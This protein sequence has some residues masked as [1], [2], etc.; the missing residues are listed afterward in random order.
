MTIKLSQKETDQI[1]Q[2][3]R[4]CKQ[5]KHADK[6]K[7]ILML[8][9]GFSCVEVGNILLLDDDTIRTYGNT[10]LSYGAGSLLSDKKN[11]KLSNSRAIRCFR[12]TGNIQ[13]IYRP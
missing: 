13:R 12:K 7:A 4:T 3:H 8:D 9:D 10:Y 2:L 1:K 5:R 11:N 6:L